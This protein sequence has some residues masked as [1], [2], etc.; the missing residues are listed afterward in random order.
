MVDETK[1][2]P[3]EKVELW[4]TKDNDLNVRITQTKEDFNKYTKLLTGKGTFVDF[5]FEKAG[6]EKNV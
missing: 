6:G 2:I 5:V 4:L 3:Y 1:I